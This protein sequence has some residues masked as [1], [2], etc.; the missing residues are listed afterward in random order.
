M[1][2][3]LAPQRTLAPHCQHMLCADSAL[4]APATGIMGVAFNVLN[5]PVAVCVPNHS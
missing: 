3:E 4:A 2:K 5:T 1:Q